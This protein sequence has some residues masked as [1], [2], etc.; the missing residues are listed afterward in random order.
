LF[1]C[2]DNAA[3]ESWNHSFKVESIHG[4][5]FKTREEAKKQIFDYIEVYYN[6]QRFHSTLGYLSPEAFEM[7][8]VA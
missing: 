6:R 4:E 3:I 5:Q 7:K 8:K 2:Y 1:D